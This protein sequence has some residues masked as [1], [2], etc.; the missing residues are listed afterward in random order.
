VLTQ[1]ETDLEFRGNGAITSNIATRMYFAQELTS[2]Q[3]AAADRPGI[4]SPRARPE[5]DEGLTAWVQHGKIRHLVRFPKPP[6][7]R[8]RTR[9]SVTDTLP[10]ERTDA[11]NGRDHRMR[12]ID[13]E[14]QELPALPPSGTQYSQ[15][16]R[17]VYFEGEFERWSEHDRA[18]HTNGCSKGCRKCHEHLLSCPP[19]CQ[20]EERL[21]NCYGLVWWPFAE[22]TET[23][24]HE[25]QRVH[26]VRWR[27]SYGPIL[28]DQVT[29][30]LLTIDHRRT[31]P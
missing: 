16:L 25:W 1:A 6:Q 29:G 12:V 7:A 27:M 21:R 26:R 10:H 14:R 28:L 15:L 2:L 8:A 4:R 9:L 17:Q 20:T 3:R 31:C 22:P 13:L 24:T 11:D 30:K 19:D 5:P 18:G 23:R